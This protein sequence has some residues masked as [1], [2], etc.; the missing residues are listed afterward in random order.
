MLKYILTLS[1]L[2][3]MLL[4]GAGYM[5]FQ[6]KATQVENKT[7]ADLQDIVKTKSD[8]VVHWI[9]QRDGDAR[10]WGDSKIVAD[11]IEA[12]LMQPDNPQ[13]KTIMQSQL[14]MMLRAHGY[15]SAMIVSFEGKILLTTDLQAGMGYPVSK[16]FDDAMASGK[17]QH[18]DFYIHP[19]QD[20]YMDWV[21][22]LI[23][24]SSL[25][26][27]PLSAFVLRIDESQALLPFI[28][29]SPGHYKSFETVL[30]T[31][32]TG[33]TICLTLP[34]DA[35]SS[36]VKRDPNHPDSLAFQ[37]KNA[38]SESG[39]GKTKDIKKNEVL[40]AYSAIDGTPWLM[41][42]KV[43]RAEILL[44]V[45]RL[46]L[47]AGMAAFWGIIT[48]C[49]ILFQHLY[50]QKKIQKMEV[51]Q[52]QTLANQRFESL[53]N[54]IPGG[55]VFRLI[56]SSEGTRGFSY[57]SQGVAKLFNYTPEQIIHDPLL[58]LS[59]MDS[60][61]K[62]LF[63]TVLSQSAENL[64]TITEEFQFNL[65]DDR[66]LW[67]QFNANPAREPDGTIVWDGVG[68]DITGHKKA[69]YDLR[70][71]EARFRRIFSES[72]SPVF[73]M[74]DDYYVDANPAALELLGY[75]SL[76]DLRGISPESISPKYQPDGKLSKEKVEEVQKIA[77]SRGSHRFEWEHLKKDGTHFFAEVT[78]TP[79]RFED[80]T[81]IHVS[82]TDI[83]ERKQMET[84]LKEFEAIVNS[85]DDAIISK[86]IHGTVLSWNKGAERLFGYKAEE[87]IG[88]SI[89][90]LLPHELSSQA[91]E[92]L[93]K[94]KQGINIDHFETRRRRKDGAIIDVSVAVSPILDKDGTVWAASK[95]ARD[96][97]E[98]K[99]IEQELHNHRLHLEELVQSRT[100]ELEAAK[101]QAE[102]ANQAKSSFLANMSHEIR[103][104]M[105]AIIGFAH[106]IRRHITEEE[107][108]EMA[109]KIIRSGK[110]L[111]GIIND[112]LDLSKIEQE[113]LILEE[114]TFLTSAIIDNVCSMIQDP[115]SNKGLHLVVNNDPELD[116]LPVIGD[117]LRI[118]QILVNYLGNA[119]KFTDQGRI[120]LTAVVSRRRA[121]DVML[122]FEVKD[123]GIGISNEQKKAVFDSFVQADTQTTRKYGGTGLGLAIC[124]QLAR[125][126]GGDAG[127]DS[128]FGKGCTF[129]FTA[130]LKIGD[131]KALKADVDDSLT[132]LRKNAR[133]L[134][135]EDNEINQEVAKDILEQFGLSVD[136]AFNGRVAVRKVEAN[137][138]DLIL[139]DM[140]MPIMDG[141]EASLTIRKMQNGVRVPIVALTANVFEE[142]RRRCLEAGMN[143]FVAKPFEP[144]Q[145]HAVLA[146]WI[147][148]HGGDEEHLYEA[149]TFEKSGPGEKVAA[150]SHI[151]QL[152][153]LKY[154]RKKETY[155]KLLNKFL[156]QQ[157]DLPGQIEAAL[158]DGDV[159]SVR[160]MVHSLKGTAGT[161]GM[162]ELHVIAAKFESLLRNYAKEGTLSEALSDLRQELKAVCEEIQRMNTPSEDRPC[163]I[164][165]D[166][167]DLGKLKSMVS[168]LSDFLSQNDMR[169]HKV[170]EKA[171]PAL[172]A[173]IDKKELVPL[174]N[175]VENFDFSDALALLN[176]LIRRYPEFFMD[177]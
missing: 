112:I 65:E 175:H 33:N 96:I 92:I 66:T 114:T 4:F 111:L 161:L 165:S 46:A 26:K 71:S 108:K 31:F 93:V 39:T 149:D 135:V 64:S 81:F 84:R 41:I 154:V 103:T 99:Q 73:L 63:H 8:V 159:E 34:S 174:K 51:E 158:K 77:F 142:D 163:A 56:L 54:N 57:I 69:E 59:R 143:G 24:G 49:F 176:D 117:P 110:H 132:E 9:R 115:I 122:R 22:P 58:M 148:G 164:D 12:F 16:A 145:L 141:L 131:P 78:L 156:V 147:P 14:D 166:S 10:I 53:S 89:K 126:M 102:A 60:A 171:Y 35:S 168:Q 50:Q 152:T 98:K 106:L 140:Q 42:A 72:R 6:S 38:V 170:W 133:V 76:E 85:S 128:E 87:I 172:K 162:N 169:V 43:D 30:L 119:V 48:I 62:A 88:R 153:G 129:W 157:P 177:E 113:A 104:P 67:M 94:L 28:K 100:E 19:S 123:T 160:L 37:L 139:M 29:S 167:V 2:L 1:C 40:F 61:S 91:Q 127:V 124:K 79:I 36:V 80:S 155:Q 105:N 97:T 136:T 44:P 144:E 55:F 70:Q 116:L 27:K 20:V 5:F 121:Q 150:L 90:Q 17:I 68:I 173:I 47:G 95:I 52:A 25:S 75:N 7:F 13:L 109:F 15:K 134:L 138:Y 45:A 11:E 74:A 125:M 101:L 18:T 118:R 146:R 120:T 107:P 86:T 21:V 137:Q 130:V 82:W 23:P 83:T 32:S 3:I 151:D